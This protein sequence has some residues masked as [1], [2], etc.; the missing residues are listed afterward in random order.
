MNSN[1]CVGRRSVLACVGTAATVWPLG[2]ARSERTGSASA[3]SP[4]TPAGRFPATVDRIVDDSH[5]VLLATARGDVVA[6][7]DVTRNA[8]PSV[9]EGDRVSVTVADSALVAVH[10][11]AGTRREI[12]GVQPTTA[13]W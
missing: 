8:L 11:A 9:Q 3:D 10:T 12:G 13:T 2:N 4:V 5:V 1:A 6:Q 7:Y